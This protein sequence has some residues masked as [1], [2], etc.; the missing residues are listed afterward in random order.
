MPVPSQ[1]D[2]RIVK[3]SGYNFIEAV[4]AEF[5]AKNSADSNIYST[6]ITDFN[7]IKSL[8]G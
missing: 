4:P 3:M 1:N 6:N 7:F 8:L 2:A 5:L